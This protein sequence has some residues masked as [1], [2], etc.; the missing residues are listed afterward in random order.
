MVRYGG[1]LQIGAPG[2]ANRIPMF[3][4]KKHYSLNKFADKDNVEITTVS[5]V[6]DLKDSQI[7]TIVRFENISFE[8][9]GK[10]DFIQEGK[11]TTEEKFVDANKATV[12]VRTSSFANTLKGIKIQL[13][14]EWN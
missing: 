6:S 14:I 13:T 1:Q 11:T 3:T 2:Q 5:K 12:T 10:N 7:N 8:N 9:G 4:F